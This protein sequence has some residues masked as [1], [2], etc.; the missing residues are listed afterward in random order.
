MTRIRNTAGDYGVMDVHSGL[1]TKRTSPRCTPLILLLV[2]LSCC[3]RRSCC[4]CSGWPVGRPP[5]PYRTA[6]PSPPPSL[7]APGPAP[8]LPPPLSS[9]L[10]SG[11][12]G[13]AIVVWNT[14]AAFYFHSDPD[15]DPDF[16]IVIKSLILHFSYF[17]FQ[18]SIF[19][20]GKMF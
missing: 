18:K 14:G 2:T 13:W 19:F 7:V 8:P 6:F 17:F 12:A 9:N 15:P 20:C 11:S 1:A 16:A 4:C 10:L 3:R 5:P